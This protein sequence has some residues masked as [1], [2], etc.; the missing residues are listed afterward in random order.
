MSTLSQWEQLLFAFAPLIVTVCLVAGVAYFRGRSNDSARD[1]PA[2][3]LQAA[4]R[5]MPENRRNWGA[6]MLAELS[7]VERGPARWKF[8]LGCARAAL[9]PP[10]EAGTTPG[11]FD[12]MKR[13]GAVCGILSVA[14][15][16][17]GLPFLYFAALAANAF[18]E[19]DDFF[20]GEVVP[21]LIGM[22]IVGSI[23]CILAGLPLGIAGLIRREQHRWLSLMGPFLSVGVFGYLMIVQHLASKNL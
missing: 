22:F 12:L 3:L 13:L 8:A 7:Q 9:F 6:A 20:N 23:V 5:Q 11:L 19:H 16:P 2:R 10:A 18:T 21:G 15:P 14:L 4:V 1:A 17:L